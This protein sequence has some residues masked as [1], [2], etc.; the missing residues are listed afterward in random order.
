MQSIFKTEKCD[1]EDAK[2]GVL[3][4]FQIQCVFKDRNLQL[5]ECII[6]GLTDII[7][8]IEKADY[9]K[10]LTT[11]FTQSNEYLEMALSP[12]SVESHTSCR[13]HDGVFLRPGEQ[14]KKSLR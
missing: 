6:S 11:S 13:S 10:S 3:F 5:N 14:Q 12:K 4:F 7:N 8:D 2:K 1:L 9:M